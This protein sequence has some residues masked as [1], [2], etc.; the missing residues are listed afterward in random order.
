MV[1]ILTHI[2]HY[3]WVFEEILKTDRYKKNIQYGQP[4]RGHVE[5]TV[6]AHIR[7]L[8]ANL[9]IMCKNS[10]ITE[11]F[12]YMRLKIL[13]HVHDS[14][15]MESKRNAAILDPQSHASLAREFLSHYTQD[16]DLLNIVQYHDIGYAVFKKL[17]EK[18]KYDGDR[19]YK[20][21]TKIHDKNLLLKFVIIDACTPSKGREMI[22]W[23]VEKVGTLFPT[24]V[25]VDKSY[26][27][28]G[29]WNVGESW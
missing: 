12:E 2:S 13:I 10:Q 24:S 16:E 1:N 21:L 9:N 23:F 26:I 19:L 22:H 3:T 4:R 18:N 29:E 6:E 17:K 20:A 14:F 25:Y 15:K 8:E 28:P 5:G 7:D 27:L 11:E